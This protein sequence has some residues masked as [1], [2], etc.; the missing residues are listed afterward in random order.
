VA[1]IRLTFLGTGAGN[2][3]HRAHTAIVLDCADGTRVLLDTGSGNSVL[4]QGV[5][6]GMLAADFAWVLLTHRHADHIGG[7]PFVQ[8][9]RAL[10]DPHG[11]PLQ[12][13]GTEETLVS[14]RRLCQVTHPALR[15]DQDQAQNPE[16]HVVMQW[17]PIAEGERVQLGPTTS[18]CAFLVDHLPGAVGWRIESAGIAIVFSGDTKFSPNLPAWAS[19]ARLLIHEAL[20]TDRDHEQTYRRGH[21]TAAEAG[22]AA[23]LAGV[24]ELLLTHID[25]PFH[26]NMQPLVNEARQRFAGPVC[27]VNDLDQVTIG[28]SPL[29]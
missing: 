17:H 27:A 21:A 11:P 8:S 15:I 16:G 7:L 29:P 18:G 5:P 14:T 12:V 13:Y 23:A 28:V 10:T 19:E 20:S 1:E 25:S 9:Q 24:A 2:C 26:C 3:I 22:Q 6:L 4:R